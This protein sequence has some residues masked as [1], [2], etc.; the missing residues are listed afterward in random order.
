[1]VFSSHLFLF[2]FLA[3]VLALYY[4]VRHNRYRTGLLAVMSYAFYGWANPPWALIMFAST[5]VDY[6]CG[7]VLLR[8][9]RLRRLPDGDWPVIPPEAPRTRSMKTVLGL[10]IASNLA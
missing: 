1:M 8:Q 3:L 6:V 2:Y 9:A 4:A 5:M 7:V 10:S